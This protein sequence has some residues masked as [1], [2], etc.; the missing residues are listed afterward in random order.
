MI[1]TKDEKKYFKR[2]KEE[3]T[4]KN[5]KM[6]YLLPKTVWLERRHWAL[7]KALKARR[8]MLSTESGHCGNVTF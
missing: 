8:M 6:V 5:E 7:F 2:P 3:K 1:E 4:W